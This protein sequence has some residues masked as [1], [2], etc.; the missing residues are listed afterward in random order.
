MPINLAFFLRST[1]AA[2]VVALYPSP[3]GAVEAP[4]AP[5]AWDAL[6]EAYPAVHAFEPDVEG[7]LVNRVGAARE[8]YRAGIDQCYRLVGIVRTHWRGLSGGSAVWD[9]VKRFFTGLKQ[10]SC[11]A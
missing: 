3:G 2:G 5:A 4:V 6:A 9:E 8:C 7:L 1:P 11:H 10:R